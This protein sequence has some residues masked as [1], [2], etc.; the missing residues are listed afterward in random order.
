MYRESQYSP[1]KYI[2]APVSSELFWQRKTNF[3][4]YI[5]G[6]VMKRE[7]Y[8]TDSLIRW[9]LFQ[10]LNEYKRCDFMGGV[11]WVRKKNNP[12]VDRCR[13]DQTKQFDCLRPY[14]FVVCGENT[15]ADGYISEKVLN[16][17]V[18]GIPIFVGP[19][20]TPNFL[21]VERMVFCAVS[22]EKVAHLR[23]FFP[24]H[25]DGRK[26]RQFTI[27]SDHQPSDEELLVWI[28]E[29]LRD[30]L[31]PCIKEVIRLDSDDE[32][33]MEKYRKPITTDDIINARDTA[34]GI[35]E[36]FQVLGN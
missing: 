31:D 5:Q 13:G 16:A 1:L 21:N 19:P 29:Q 17:A 25:P 4:A 24:D 18:A 9:A 23:S 8:D 3:C 30:D 32:M 6:S 28:V 36:L 34:E 10:L 22:A 12:D 33:Y 26:H 2:E 35:A 7:F 15:V 11:D 20:D 14:K 27:F